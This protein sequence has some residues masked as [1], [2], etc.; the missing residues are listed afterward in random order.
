MRSVW[1][2]FNGTRRELI[3]KELA[4]ARDRQ[5]EV[6]AYWNRHKITVMDRWDNRTRGRGE[7]AVADIPEVAA[8]WHQDN[9]VHP[10]NVS[11]TA[12]RRGEVSPYMWQCPLAFCHEPWPAWPKD[13]IQKGAECPECRRLI[14]LADLPTLAAQYR[15]QTPASDIT[16]AS[17]ESVPWACRTWSVDPSTGFWQ[18]VEHCF[19]AVI[20][21]RALQGDG[22]LVCAGYV[23]DDTNSLL[24]WFP[25]IADEL[26]APDLDER[27]LP[28][29][30]H[31]ISRKRAAEA[32]GAGTYATL[33]WRCRH[34]H[35][36]EATIL[37]RVQGTGCGKCSTSG[38][39][40]EQVRLVAELSGLIDLLT[41][42]SRDPRLPDGV[43]DFASHRLTVPPEHKPAHWRYK[44]V[45][46]DAVF[47][48][49][50][51]VR[52]GLEYDGAFHHSARQR[53]RRQYE[54]DKSRVLVEAGLL[55]LLIHVRIGDL[56]EME[57]PHALVVAV[58]E[59]A[60]AYQQASAVASA[61]SA[62][63][64]EAT[65]GLDAYLNGGMARHEAVADAYITAVW[66][67]LR[68]PRLKPKKAAPPTPRRLSPTA[69][70]A[71]SLLSP[72][73]EPYRNP[74][75]PDEIV[76]DYRCGCGNPEIITSVQSQVTS[77]NTRSCG[78]LATQAR[79]RPRP[80]ISK[81]E[82]HAVRA[83]AQQ[84]AIAI[85]GSG[86]VPDRMT[87]SFRLDQAG[88]GDLLGP[89]GLLAEARVREWAVTAGLQ[90]GARGGVTGE[91]WL[92]YSTNELAAGAQI[93]EAP[94]PLCGH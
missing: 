87:A 47:H 49:P 46:V 43:P 1:E 63:F 8:Q 93:K 80:V 20:K 90:L 68:P 59:R 67:E 82:T 74:E 36:W 85:G 26:D 79:Q 10:K 30:Q 51:G 37:N 18:P 7:M 66:G 28:T 15:G 21:E 34:G 12:Q 32:G 86:R 38:I 55:D 13:R 39:S 6:V 42:T 33:P 58:P 16:H 72:V 3:K 22:C 77:G 14:R 65:P 75:N 92:D 56:P 70:H 23:I 53:D 61:L 71:D 54:N 11:A 81:T 73:S 89:D 24:T 91:L 40:K 84:R 31:S 78:C 83:W 57:A 9:L 62:R 17:H 41:P 25:E 44:D 94:D 88:R 35:N 60:T 2:D 50:H 76:R 5:A 64:P 29:S 52:V 19:E 69:P 4:V 48:L 27:R 45:E